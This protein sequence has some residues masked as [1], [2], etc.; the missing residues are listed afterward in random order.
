[1]PES[2]PNILFIFADQLRGSSLGHVGQEPVLTPHMDAFAA[3]GLSFTRAVANAPVCG[4][5]RATL[6]TGLHPLSHGVVTNDVRLREDVTSIADVL[7]GR[8][9]QSAYIGKWHLDGPDRGGFTPPGP[10]RHGFDSW[11][12]FNCN[13]NYFESFYYRDFSEPIWIDGYEPAA[14]TD[15]A[16]DYLRRA[17]GQADPF[18][19]FL[20]WGPPH[21][22]YDHVPLRFRQLYDSAAMPL[23]PNVVNPNRETI[24]NYYA[25]VSA[26]DWNFGRLM[27]ALAELGLSSNTL[28]VFTSDHGDMLYSQNRGWKCKP[29]QESVIVPFIVRWPGRVPAG[30]REDTP[31]GLVDVMPS[32]LGLCGAPIPPEVQGIDLSHLF[33]GTPG[34]RPDSQIIHQ[35]I[36]PISYSFR[37]WRGIITRTHTYA[38]FRN[39]SW[40][41][42]NDENDPYQLKNLNVESSGVAKRLDLEGKLRAWLDRLGDQ[43]E[44]TD[45]LAARYKLRLNDQGIYPYFYQPP[46][47][48][49]MNRRAASRK[50]R[51]AMA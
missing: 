28:V 40:V 44:T 38:R 23:R 11:A 18:C 42:Y 10:R 47:L 19:L 17:S 13:H 33:L 35:H 4:P 26:L 9:Y 50:E 12:A 27:K 31:L 51:K 3:E 37:E 39:E 43:F 8:G 2:C 5:M 7:R 32:L 41:C 24:A 29:W 20:S 45:Q 34:F 16:I 25:H 49:E 36:S 21:C 1:M 46:I 30:G 15:L 6:M 22:P 48:E 14:Q